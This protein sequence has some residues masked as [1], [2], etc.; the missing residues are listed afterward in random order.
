MD[1]EVIW[2][3]IRMYKV[4]DSLCLILVITTISSIMIFGNMIHYTHALDK[5]NLQLSTNK[6]TYKPGETVV[7]TVKNNG[8]GTLE[9]PDSTLG[10]ILQNTKTHQMAGILG[11]Q[12]MSELK[13]GESKTV[14]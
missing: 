13:P 3:V 14:Q 8:N 11:S 1:P 4:S 12:V 9:F 10:L 6:K 7:I 5:S 2:S